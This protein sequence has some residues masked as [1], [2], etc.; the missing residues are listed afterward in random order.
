M[1][2]TKVTTS[3]PTGGILRDNEERTGQTTPST[4]ESSVLLSVAAAL[5]ST[6]NATNV[7]TDAHWDKLQGGL[8]ALAHGSGPATAGVAGAN[9]FMTIID[10]KVVI[11]AV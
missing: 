1:A 11:D 7:T 10:G 6:S 2:T 4:S 5:A 8:A 9:K 3:I